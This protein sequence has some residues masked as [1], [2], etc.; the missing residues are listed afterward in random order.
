VKL[1]DVQAFVEC[2]FLDVFCQ[3]RIP[4]AC[5]AG[6][7]FDMFLPFLPYSTIPPHINIPIEKLIDA[8]VESECVLF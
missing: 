5:P 7:L 8:T 2:P 3:A 6:I 1:V 4:Q